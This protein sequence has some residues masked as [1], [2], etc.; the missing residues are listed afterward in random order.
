MEHAD[1]SEKKKKK[2]HQVSR[3]GRVIK[4][5]KKILTTSSDEGPRGRKT[6]VKNRKNSMVGHLQQLR[7]MV[8]EMDKKGPKLD[9]IPPER[10][11]SSIVPQIVKRTDTALV[12]AEV[13]DE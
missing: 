2:A 5:P 4:R 7:T 3:T 6:V 10:S 12:T 13:N 11:P 8:A 1:N 9:V